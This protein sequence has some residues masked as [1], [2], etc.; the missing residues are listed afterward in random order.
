MPISFCPSQ[1]ASA[2]AGESLIA[3]DVGAGKTVEAGLVLREMLLRRRSRFRRWSPPRQEWSD[4]GR[5]SLRPSSA[6]HSR[7]LTA[8][9]WRSFGEIADLV[10]IL[11]PRLALRHLPLAPGRRN[12]RFAASAT[13]SAASG[14]RAMLILDEA[15]HAAPASGSRYAIDSQFTRAVRDL[16]GRFEHRLFLS[17]T[18]A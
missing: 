10:P 13:C 3:D 2:A 4:S 7:P 17:A 18:P 1:G 8:S 11:G 16:A 5:M 12:L 14:P 6:S 15:H 9:S